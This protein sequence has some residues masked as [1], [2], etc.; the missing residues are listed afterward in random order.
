MVLTKSELIAAL[1]QEVRI[2]LHLAGKIDAPM[3]DYR[4]TPKPR[5]TLERLQYLA[6]MGPPL[7]QYAKT[8]RC[9][10]DAA[11]ARTQ[12]IRVCLFV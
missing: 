12:E 5:S 11:T 9:N 1:Q 3:L 4:P 10:R 2:L 7:L 6:E 8:G